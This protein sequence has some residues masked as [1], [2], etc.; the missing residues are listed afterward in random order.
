MSVYNSKVIELATQ[1]ENVN[2][3]LN[4]K[5]NFL[6]TSVKTSRICGSKIELS[7]VYDKK[8]NI[9]TD[10]SIDPK[11]CA[12]GQASAAILSRNLIGATSQDVI[13]ARDAL[14]KMLKEN[15]K[16]PEGRFWELRYLE[17]VADYPPRHASVMLA[18]EAA[19]A[20]FDEMFAKE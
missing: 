2:K 4:V 15:G 19:C 5:D 12:L 20:I 13:K 10:F 14:K 11:A 16:P 17:A 7:I 1:I 3:L 9:I 18:W 6:G 8:E